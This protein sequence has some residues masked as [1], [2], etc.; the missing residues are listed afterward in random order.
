LTNKPSLEVGRRLEQLVARL[1]GMRPTAELLRALRGIESLEHIGTPAA[2]EV[3]VK[4][5]EG[6]PLAPLTQAAKASLARL[7]PR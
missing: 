7:Q 5:G 4:L 1:Q 2:R 6:S 3:L